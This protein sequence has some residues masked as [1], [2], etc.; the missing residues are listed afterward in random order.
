VRIVE[1]T[2]TVEEL[3]DVLQTLRD[4]GEDLTHIEAKR[5][6][7]PLPKRLWETLPAFAITPG[8]GIIPLGLDEDAGFQVVGVRNPAKLQSDLAS[9][10]DVVRQG[11]LDQHGARRWTHYTIATAAEI[12]RPASEV[13]LAR[14]PRDTTT[15]APQSVELDPQSVELAAFPMSLPPRAAPRPVRRAILPLCRAAPLTSEEL[16]EYLRRDRTYLLNRHLSPL[17]AAGLLER[18]GTAVT[19]PNMRYRTTDA[20]RNLLP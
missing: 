10:A 17:V 2:M 16:A 12:P 9:L 6:E 3:E 1:L 11:L 20:G 4:V 14:A 15:R 7:N 8:G 18:L 13:E 19:D 5:A